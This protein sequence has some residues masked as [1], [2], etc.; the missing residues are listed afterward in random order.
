MRAHLAIA[1]NATVATPADNSREG[2]ER[3]FLPVLNDG[4]STLQSR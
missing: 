2:R 3:R 1:D 4:V